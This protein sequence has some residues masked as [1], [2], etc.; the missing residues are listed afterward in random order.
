AEIVSDGKDIL[1]PPEICGDE[2]WLMANA[3]RDIPVIVSKTRYL[4]GLKAN[5]HFK[6]NFFIL[7]D[8]FQHILL[9]RDMDIVLAD[10][11]RPFGNGHLLPW[12]PLREPLTGLKRAD[13][14]LLTRSGDLNS[15]KIKFPFF[16]KPLFTGDHSPDK[17]VFPFSAD[18]VDLSYLSGKRIIAFSGIAR[19][20]S[21]RESLMHLG[22][23][24]ASFMT[25]GDHYPFSKKDIERIM[26]EKKTQNGELV[27]TTEKDWARI[28]EITSGID[29]LAFLSIKFI[30]TSGKD[31]LFN[32]I[33]EK[34]DSAL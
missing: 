19:P 31:K 34:A 4:A 14:V 16:N 25:F 21:F 18:K 26:K 10:A 5:Q 30:I 27:I 17:I 6:S 32:L 1:L 24:V 28:R 13:A 2:P 23:D 29:S 33:K 7:D 15:Q 3:L 8:G 12:G 22:A 20:E 11:K 9:K